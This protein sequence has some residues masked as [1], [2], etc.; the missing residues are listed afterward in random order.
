MLFRSNF[1]DPAKMTAFLAYL[2]VLLRLWTI[3]GELILAV[4]SIVFDFGGLMGRS[5]APGRVPVVIDKPQG[6]ST[7]SPPLAA[8]QR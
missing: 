4:V 7:A 1:N 5:D 8:S 2:S 6:S 3:V